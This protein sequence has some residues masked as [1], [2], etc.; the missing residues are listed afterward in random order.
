MWSLSAG[1]VTA[2]SLGHWSSSAPPH[3]LPCPRNPPPPSQHHVGSLQGFCASPS[4]TPSLPS[5]PPLPWH[6]LPTNTSVHPLPCVKDP[7]LT[8]PTSGSLWCCPGGAKLLERGL[9][10]HLPLTLVPHPSLLGSPPTPPKQFLLI[11]TL[12]SLWALVLCA[13]PPGSPLLPPLSDISCLDVCMVRAAFP[14]LPRS[15]GGT[16]L[17]KSSQMAEFPTDLSW[18]LYFSDARLSLGHL[19]G[20]ADSGLLFPAP[21]LRSSIFIPYC[22]HFLTGLPGTELPFRRWRGFK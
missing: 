12:P 21:G 8:P 2:L 7:S 16:S 20:L 22:N 18:G 9:S 6:L 14:S 1:A 10:P 13:L 15:F 4:L 3:L 19:L 5:T 17:P 11:L